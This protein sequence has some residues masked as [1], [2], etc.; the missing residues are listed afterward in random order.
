MIITQTDLSNKELTTTVSRDKN[1]IYIE[2]FYDDG[3]FDNSDDV[4]LKITLPL[5]SAKVLRKELE[6]W[7]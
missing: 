2:F 3:S 4:L 6:A 1:K 7:L 5:E